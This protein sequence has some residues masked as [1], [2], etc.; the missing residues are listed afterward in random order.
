MSAGKGDADRRDLKAYDKGHA[1][2]KWPS[3]QEP[4]YVR[5]DRE[6]A[7]KKAKEK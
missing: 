6:A 2:V 1:K 7:E 3:S 4:W 5:R